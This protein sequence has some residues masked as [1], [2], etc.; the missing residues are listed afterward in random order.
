MRQNRRQLR[1][2]RR[3]EKSDPSPGWAETAYWEDRKR[4]PRQGSVWRARPRPWGSRVRGAL[5]RPTRSQSWR[6][7]HH[8]RILPGFRV[9]VPTRRRGVDRLP[10]RA[11]EKVVQDVDVVFDAVGG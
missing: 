2:I 1:A 10:N 5:R 11:F 6:A 8:D 4:I 7:R 3:P 9:L